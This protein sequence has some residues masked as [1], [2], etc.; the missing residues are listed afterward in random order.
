MFPTAVHLTNKRAATIPMATTLAGSSSISTA[1]HSVCY[2]NSYSIVVLL[3]TDAF[4][5]HRHLG[6]LQHVC[7]STRM[8]C[9]T[10]TSNVA[11]RPHID[12]FIWQTYRLH[13]FGELNRF[14]KLEY[15]NVVV[16]G[17]GTLVTRVLEYSLDT[18]F[19]LRPLVSC[20]IVF[21]NSDGES[22][23][24]SGPSGNTMG[25]GHYMARTNNRTSTSTTIVVQHQ[26]LP[27]PGTTCSGRSSNDTLSLDLG[28]ATYS[29][30]WSRGG[31]WRSRSVWCWFTLAAAAFAYVFT[32]FWA[33]VFHPT[34]LRL[35]VTHS[36]IMGTVD[37]PISAIYCL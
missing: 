31:C 22:G 36:H 8:P 13:V 26:D 25:C 18:I 5:H 4:A 11:F 3:M 15:C 30:P 17:G 32:T 19:L 7:H 21:P 28:F 24:V 34:H 10:P 2:W 33:V 1:D 27:W 23:R 29:C 37:Q 6:L 35:A 12:T 20:G 16:D 9:F 14:L